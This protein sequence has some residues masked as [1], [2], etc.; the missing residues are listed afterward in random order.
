V[1][2]LVGMSNEFSKTKSLKYFNGAIR[3][4]KLGVE[5]PPFGMIF[6]SIL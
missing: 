4:G 1:K 5:L 2:I 3:D 6:L